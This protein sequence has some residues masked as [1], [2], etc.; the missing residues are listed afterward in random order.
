MTFE[1]LVIAAGLVVGFLKKGNVW[2][3]A[4]LRLKVLWMLPIPYVLQHISVFYLHGVLYEAVL[5][6]S[7]ILLIMFCVTNIRVP[8]VAWSLFGTL[9][10]FV[11]LAANGLRM[12]AYVPAVRAMAPSI[13]PSLEAGTYG[14]SIAMGP[15]THLNFLADIFGV[16]LWPGSL[17]SIG[18]ILFC[19][20]LIVLIQYAMRLRNE[21]RAVNGK[22]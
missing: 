15:S 17:L 18:D 1:I 19:I 3:M 10:N 22:A 14:K 8:G 6:V 13:L 5:V 4:N 9:A 7:Y 2:N 11:A 12:P 16:D 20:G 21:E